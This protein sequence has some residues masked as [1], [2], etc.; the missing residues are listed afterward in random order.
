MGD[1]RGPEGKGNTICQAR[2]LWNKLWIEHEIFVFFF[3]RMFFS[4]YADN[5]SES[6]SHHCKST[7]LVSISVL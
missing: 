2:S 7:C 4:R 6:N 5:R 3:L 1:I